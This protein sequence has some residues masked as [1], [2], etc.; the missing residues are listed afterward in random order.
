MLNS[1]IKFGDILTI[2]THTIAY[3]NCFISIALHVLAYE[4]D[5]FRQ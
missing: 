2:N 4:V 5:F 3:R 1:L